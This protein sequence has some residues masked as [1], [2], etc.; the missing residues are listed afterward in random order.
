MPDPLHP[1]LQL[2]EA[3][4]AVPISEIRRLR[5]KIMEKDHMFLKRRSQGSYVVSLALK[6][7]FPLFLLSHVALAPLRLSSSKNV[8]K[9]KDG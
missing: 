5:F 3:G 6:F 7:A 9:S 1:A 2:C 8:A 4:I